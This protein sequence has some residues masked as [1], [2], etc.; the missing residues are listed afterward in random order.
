MIENNIQKEILSLCSFIKSG[1][2]YSQLKPKTSTI[3]NDLYNYHLQQLVKNGYLEKTDNLYFLTQ[4]GKSVV[5]NIDEETMK[6]YTNYKVSTYLCPVVNNKILLYKRLKHPQYGYTGF[7]SAK[8]AYGERALDTAKREFMEETSMEADF[9]IIGN[10]RQIRHSAEDK[11]IEDGI[12][13]IC[14]TDKVSGTLLETNKEGEY[15]W[16]DIDKVH[17]IDKIFKPSL[18][19]GVNE[20]IK[21]LNGTTSWDSPFIC[22]LEP[23][24]EEY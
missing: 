5:T 20:I 16:V 10:M 22:E 8:I 15:F 2:K 17:E 23:D 21:R 6:I 19:I 11:V 9:K 12:F 1:A 3:E 18:E 4:H 13:Y 24:P 7:I 14:Y